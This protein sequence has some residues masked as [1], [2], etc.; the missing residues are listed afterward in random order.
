MFRKSLYAAA[1]RHASQQMIDATHQLDLRRD[2]F[3]LVE[4]L[5]QEARD[6]GLSGEAMFS[7]P[8]T[9]YLKV[10]PHVE[11]VPRLAELAAR[12]GLNLAPNHAGSWLLV[13]RRGP[14]RT[15]IEV[16]EQA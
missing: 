9:P 6:V 5:A 10:Q 12:R 13:G 16:R 11:L 2:D 15:A 4:G 8:A 7:P 1:L 3:D 14:V